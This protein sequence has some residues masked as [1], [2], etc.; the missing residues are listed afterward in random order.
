MWSL[1]TTKDINDKRY[2]KS[3]ENTALC[4]RKENEEVCNVKK[5]IHND[6]QKKKIYPYLFQ[7]ECYRTSKLLIPES[8]T[9]RLH[10]NHQKISFVRIKRTINS[11]RY[12]TCRTY[13]HPKNMLVYT[14]HEKISH[15]KDIDPIIIK[16]IASILTTEYLNRKKLADKD[17][18]ERSSH[19]RYNSIHL[20]LVTLEYQWWSYGLILEGKMYFCIHTEIIIRLLRNIVEDAA[21]LH[22]VRT[23]FHS[24]ILD[25]KQGPCIQE[26]NDLKMLSIFCSNIYCLE[27]QKLFFLAYQRFLFVVTKFSPEIF[28]ED[29]SCINKTSTW[30]NSN[31]EMQKCDKITNR[32]N[33]LFYRKYTSIYKYV[34]TKKKWL[35]NIQ[36]K[37][38]ITKSIYK[39]YI[40]YLKN[41][42]GYLYKFNKL[43]LILV[44]HSISLLGYTVAFQLKEIS[45][46]LLNL[47][48]LLKNSIRV[49][50]LRIFVPFLVMTHILAIYG[51]CTRQSYPIAKLE[52]TTWPDSIIITRFKHLRDSL[53][54]YYSG[55]GNQKDLLR[56]QHILHYSCA[57]TLACKHK[58]NL[59]RIW[60]KYGTN[61]CTL[62]P[63]NSKTVSFDILGKKN[64]IYTQRNTRFWNMYFK[65]PDALSLLVTQTF[66]Y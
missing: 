31:L 29:L 43:Q 48:S 65:Q 14:N 18:Y 9:I 8:S 55:S 26:S 11:I 42:F 63:Y 62:S 36:A 53:L 1:I 50:I 35:L 64:K 10:E 6:W 52:W 45:I 3:P 22:I 20:S 49:K 19:H 39:R 32:E 40:N 57:K 58:T 37:T 34:H 44:N 54:G 15:T 21:F 41:R 38:S 51:F 24:V 16:P 28:H 4:S 7:E 27:I 61:L 2:Y 56:I 5:P 59:R 12:N 30:K 17:T 46:S 60:K 13:F 33:D 23:I 47:Q 25:S 66:T